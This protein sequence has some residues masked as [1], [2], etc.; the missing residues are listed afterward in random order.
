MDEIRLM[1]V[2][3]ELAEALRTLLDLGHPDCTCSP[4]YICPGCQ[5]EAALTAYDNLNSRATSL[6]SFCLD[7]DDDDYVVI[8]EGQ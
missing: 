8:D 3:E 7:E 6:P 2:S 4:G 1:Y 5:A